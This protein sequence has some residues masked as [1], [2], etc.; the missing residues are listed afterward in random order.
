MRSGYEISIHPLPPF[1]GLRISCKAWYFILY[2]D[3]FLQQVM[4]FIL[5]ALCFSSMCFTKTPFRPKRKALA[6]EQHLLD[7]KD[8]SWGDTF[9]QE[10]TINQKMGGVRID[11]EKSS[12]KPSTHNRTARHSNPYCIKLKVKT[13]DNCR[14]KFVEKV[15]CYTEHI[16][17]LALSRS[18]TKPSCLTEYGYREAKYFTVFKCASL[19]LDCKCAT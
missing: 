7:D 15:E 3:V 12:E 14:R 13:W 1:F 9:Q 6:G 16:S 10:S 19:P 2:A 17:C 11:S 8:W 5:I 18:I 4:M